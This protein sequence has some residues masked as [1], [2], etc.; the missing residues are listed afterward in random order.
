MHSRMKLKVM[1]SVT[2]RHPFC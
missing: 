2:H 1:T